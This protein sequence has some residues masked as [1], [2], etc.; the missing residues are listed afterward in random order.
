M[1]LRRLRLMTIRRSIMDRS[2]HQA[3]LLTLALLIVLCA[4][5]AKSLDDDVNIKASLLWR[6][7]TGY[8]IVDGELTSSDDT[9]A[10]ATFKNDINQTGW[11]YL[12]VKTFS[13][14]DDQKQ[15]RFLPP[16]FKRRIY[17]LLYK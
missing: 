14:F 7:I 9:L 11:T 13:R 4:C 2:N 6:P 16:F 1:C 12:E 17:A 10:W 15:V 3:S 8:T 5:S